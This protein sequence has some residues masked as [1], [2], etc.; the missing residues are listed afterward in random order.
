MSAVKKTGY[1]IIIFLL[2]ACGCAHVPTLEYPLEIEKS[3]NSSFDE[4]WDSVIEVIESSGGIIT[5]HDKHSGLIT[6]KAMHNT[7]SP[8]IFVN[9]YVTQQKQGTRTFATPYACTHHPMSKTLEG[10]II[11]KFE[12][13]SC[14]ENYEY[15]NNRYFFEELGKKLGGNSL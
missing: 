7:I 1:R 9:V 12:D 14:R 6:F 15:E 13:I 8:K 5:A 11:V 2:V 10:G 4:A 3:F